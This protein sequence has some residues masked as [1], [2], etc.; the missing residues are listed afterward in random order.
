MK[1]I[2]VPFDGS[3]TALRALHHAAAL[4]RDNPAV[5][6]D[7]LHV[8]DPTTARSYT[9]LSPEELTRLAPDAF[10]RLMQPAREFLDAQGIPYQ[11]HC[12]L[13]DP[14]TQIADHVA[15]AGSAAVVMGTRGLGPMENLTIGS[16]AS[17]VVYY[18]QVPVTL[19]K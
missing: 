5:R 9:A 16:V 6:L 18:V 15:D 10:T 7:L 4:A 1:K 3:D 17:R 12:R 13:G 11:A 14:A 8:L 2:L 19:I